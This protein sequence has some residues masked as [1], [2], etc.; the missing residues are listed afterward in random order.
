[1]CGVYI[2]NVPFGGSGGIGTSDLLSAIPGKQQ[3]TNKQQTNKKE[4]KKKKRI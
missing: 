2:I 3:T 1:M 4:T